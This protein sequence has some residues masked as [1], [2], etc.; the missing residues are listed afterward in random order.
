MVYQLRQVLND[1]GLSIAQIR[2]ALAPSADRHLR[3]VLP[4]T[5]TSG[6]QIG[7]S[8]SFHGDFM[9]DGPEN[10]YKSTVLATVSHKN[11]QKPD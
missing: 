9:T 1:S 10:V 4:K 5:R 8:V 7:A 6:F 2:S 3:R 11:R